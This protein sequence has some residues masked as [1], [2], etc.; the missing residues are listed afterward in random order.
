MKFSQLNRN[1]Y[2]QENF[3][4]AFFPNQKSSRL[5]TQFREKLLSLLKLVL[6]KAQGRQ[7]NKELERRE[8]NGVEIARTI[9]EY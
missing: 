9:N 8:D 6:K 3:K 2:M 4:I 5:L 7:H 1:S